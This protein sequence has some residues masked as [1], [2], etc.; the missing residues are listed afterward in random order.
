M[1]QYIFFVGLGYVTMVQYSCTHHGD[2]ILC[3]N[4]LYFPRLVGNGSCK[5]EHSFTES[6][7]DCLILRNKIVN[8]EI[9]LHLK[10]CGNM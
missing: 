10:S 7:E 5:L 9:S 3:E 6:T 8:C 4:G 2:L 1:D